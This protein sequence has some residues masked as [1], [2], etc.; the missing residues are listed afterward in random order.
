MSDFEKH[1]DHRLFEQELKKGAARLVELLG[2]GQL[3]QAMEQ[4]EKLNVLRH[5]ALYHE[6]GTLTR[7][8]HSAI[9]DLTDDV[10]ST[11]LLQDSQQHI[12]SISDASD[13][14]SY[15]IE[16][17]EVNA[18]KTIDKVDDALQHVTTLER[19]CARRQELIDDLAALKE[20][21]P[22][23]EALYAKACRYTEDQQ[24]VLVALKERLMGILL[25]QEYQDIT[26]QLIKRVIQLVADIENKLVDLME[27]ASRV[28]SLGALPMT[29]NTEPKATAASADTQ[30]EGPQM[31]GRNQGA[32]ASS[33]DDVD[34]L[35]S[36]LGF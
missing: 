6:V 10:S 5:Q 8:V 18:H 21:S 1:Y 16:L 34:D 33:Q 15:V 24:S 36:S 2:Q 31:K 23:L 9:V 28:N 7:A 22:Q 20:G 3:P 19:D 30:A 17:T 12:A 14:L 4:V 13:R 25:A 32:V 29:E 35:L 27:L 26:G 11:D